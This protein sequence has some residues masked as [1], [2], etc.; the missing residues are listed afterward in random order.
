MYFV[1]SS[2]EVVDDIVSV[3]LSSFLSVPEEHG[4]GL[5]V[6]LSPFYRKKMLVKW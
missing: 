1:S 2:E 4:K 5:T 3:V 6:S